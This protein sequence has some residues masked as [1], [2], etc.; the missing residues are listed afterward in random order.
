MQRLTVS[1]S[2]CTVDIMR[3]LSYV[4]AVYVR[5]IFFFSSRRRHTR[6]KCDWSSDVCSSDLELQ[7]HLN[8]DALP[9]NQHFMKGTFPISHSYVSP[10]D[11][12]GG[13]EA[14]NFVAQFGCTCPRFIRPSV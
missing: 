4:S 1:E 14:P 8:L 11:P 5:I 6:F 10:S 7:S 13:P 12:P 2:D 9:S 3:G